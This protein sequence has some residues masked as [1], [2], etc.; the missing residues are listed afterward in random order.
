MA[1]LIGSPLLKVLMMKLIQ[2][3]K[4]SLKWVDRFVQLLHLLFQ[5][6][7]RQELQLQS[8]ILFKPT[9]FTEIIK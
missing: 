5:D 7:R 1:D 6:K 4:L 9:M 8:G 3:L 2:R